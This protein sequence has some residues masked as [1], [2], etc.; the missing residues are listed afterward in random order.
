MVFQSPRE[1]VGELREFLRWIEI[2]E[3]TP[4]LL[5]IDARGKRYQVQVILHLR[6]L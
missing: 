5:N 1:V 3:F 6:G 4:A 2:I